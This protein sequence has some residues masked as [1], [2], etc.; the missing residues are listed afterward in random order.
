[1]LADWGPV[2]IRAGRGSRVSPS[3]V[4]DFDNAAKRP[5]IVEQ[6]VANA[7]ETP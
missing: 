3:I 7:G 6:A 2:R 5:E 1:M 4:M